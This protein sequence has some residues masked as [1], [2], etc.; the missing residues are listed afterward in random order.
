MRP[1]HIKNYILHAT[2]LGGRSH[3]ARLFFRSRFPHAALQP[4]KLRAH[5][6]LPDSLF[7]VLGHTHGITYGKGR[8]FVVQPPSFPNKNSRCMSVKPFLS[9]DLSCSNSSS[10]VSGSVGSKM[11]DPNSRETSDLTLALSAANILFGR[12]IISL[13]SPN[14]A[15]RKAQHLSTISSDLQALRILPRK[16]SDA[17]SSE[18]RSIHAKTAVLLL[19]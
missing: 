14:C 7:C 15:P 8:L 17:I 16:L 3:L 1:R 2:V 10:G 4:L 9:S 11:S 18:V 19:L 6:R 12:P 13:S 5:A